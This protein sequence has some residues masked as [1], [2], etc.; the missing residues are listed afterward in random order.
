MR[1][2]MWEGNSV[3]AAESISLRKTNSNLF[4]NAVQISPGDSTSGFL[5]FYGSTEG[6][7][8]G[9]PPVFQSSEQ[10]GEGAE[11]HETFKYACVFIC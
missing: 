5:F 11:M 3:P 1:P 6:H 2:E 4:L 8:P 9:S 10:T 7:S